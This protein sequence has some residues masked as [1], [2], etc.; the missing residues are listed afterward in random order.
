MASFKFNKEDELIDFLI[1]SKDP[2][3]D[4]NEF[5]F[6]E[7]EVTFL[8]IRAPLGLELSINTKG[9]NLNNDIEY[10]TWKKVRNLVKMFWEDNGLQRADIDIRL[11]SP[12]SI[13][14]NFDPNE[15]FQSFHLNFFSSSDVIMMTN[16]ELEKRLPI[17]YEPIE[18][19]T[20]YISKI[21]D[22]WRKTYKQ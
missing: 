18:K 13:K 2:S 5:I 15:N 22:D 8:V 17:P 20:A 21:L 3:A 12:K 16:T 1:N 11:K 10:K 7:W 14:I 4:L 6:D 9:I 19:W